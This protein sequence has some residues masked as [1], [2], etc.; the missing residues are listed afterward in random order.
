MHGVVSRLL[1]ASEL[2]SEALILKSVQLLPLLPM[3]TWIQQMCLESGAIHSFA[4]VRQRVASKRGAESGDLQDATLS[5][6]VQSAIRGVFSGNLELCSWAL[7]DAFVGDTFVCIEVLEELQSLEQQ[8]RGTFR[9][10]D[11][12]FD[13][14]SKAKRTSE[15]LVRIALAAVHNN[16]QLRL[17][18][19]VNYSENNVV[20]VMV[21]CL[22]AGSGLSAI[23]LGQHRNQRSRESFHSTTHS[24]IHTVWVGPSLY[25]SKL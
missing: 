9:R 4:L 11:A 19:A 8:R 14:I 17:Q 7:S 22:Q 24:S 15:V 13:V 6:A 18:L 5:K 20:V 23:G 2:P 21:T 10:L 25:F 16:A 1:A 12:D 3:E